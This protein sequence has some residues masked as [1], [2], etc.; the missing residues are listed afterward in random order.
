MM[1][2]LLYDQV[3]KLRKIALKTLFIRR[4]GYE[5][6]P[7]KQ[8]II[9]VDVVLVLPRLRSVSVPLDSAATG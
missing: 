7:I 3:C 5:K 4:I 2:I 6:R 1:Q 9:I 8:E